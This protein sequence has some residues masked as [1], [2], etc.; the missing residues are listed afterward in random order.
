MKATFG[1]KHARIPRRAVGEMLAM[2][3]GAAL[4]AARRPAAGRYRRRTTTG[5]LQGEQAELAI[6]AIEKQILAAQI[7]LA[8]AKPS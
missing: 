4:Q 5:S 6:G 8:M 1:G 3:G 2:V 7:R